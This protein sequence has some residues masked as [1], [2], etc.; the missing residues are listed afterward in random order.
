MSHSA[1]GALRSII[2]LP[3]TMRRF[4][5]CGFGEK[6]L[7]RRLVNGTIGNRR[8]GSVAQQIVEEVRRH[9]L[10]VC[11]IGKFLFFDK[12]VG[13]QPVEQLGAERPDDLALRKMQVRVDETRQDQMGPVI[14]DLSIG[15]LCPYLLIAAACR[16]QAVLDSDRAIFF[17][18][19]T[20][21]I[22]V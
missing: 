6:R 10:A 15:K 2:T 4:R 17:I 3:P 14:D 7:R 16:N 9:A 13:I 11:R 21:V 8:G 1:S 20:G 19:V 12:G 22:I 18:K 5:R